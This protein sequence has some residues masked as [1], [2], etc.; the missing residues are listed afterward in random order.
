MEPALV[1]GL[2]GALA[3]LPFEF[4]QKFPDFGFGR[5]GRHGREEAM[6]GSARLDHNHFQV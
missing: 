6:I 2:G 4:S 3:K 1:T 5:F